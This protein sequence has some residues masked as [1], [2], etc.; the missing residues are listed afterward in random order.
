LAK[1]KL[2]FG[3]KKYLAEFAD[4]APPPPPPNYEYANNGL[5]GASSFKFCAYNSAF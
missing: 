4:L 3:V 2:F 1:I 5:F